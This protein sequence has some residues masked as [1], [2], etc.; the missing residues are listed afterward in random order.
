[1]AVVSSCE[2][3]LLKKLTTFIEDEKQI[4][5]YRS[6]CRR[7]D[8]DSSTARN[9]LQKYLDLRQEK[10]DGELTVVYSV[11]GEKRVN[12]ITRIVEAMVFKDDFE[13]WTE[14]FRNVEKQ[15]FSVQAME[16][17]D[18]DALYTVDHPIDDDLTSLMR[19]SRINCSYVHPR[20]RGE[21]STEECF[22]EPDVFT[23][24]TIVKVEEEQKK[25]FINIS[26][27]FPVLKQKTPKVAAEGEAKSKENGGKVEKS[28]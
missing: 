12:D 3:E 27:S 6:V 10:Y 11:S 20:S 19:S 17:D 8:V 15:V 1:M 24:K 16:L 28:D 21:R 13:K 25:M 18:P 26:A 7:F 4:I 23:S 9:L 14:D 2:K 22:P 5:T